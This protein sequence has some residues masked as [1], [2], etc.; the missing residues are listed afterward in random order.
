MPD[1]PAEPSILADNHVNLCQ[2]Y[3]FRGNQNNIILFHPRCH[4]SS[5]KLIFHT[6]VR[7]NQNNIIL[8]HRRCH[9]S[10]L[11]LIFHTIK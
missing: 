3:S 9:C 4:C 7:G 1:E 8:F 2:I 5:L 6:I 11:K 10:S